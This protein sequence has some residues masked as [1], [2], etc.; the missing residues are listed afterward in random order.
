MGDLIPTDIVN[1]ICDFI[2]NNHLIKIA[3]SCSELHNKLE[4]RLNI[5][6]QRH[7]LL[8]DISI[9]VNTDRC[10]SCIDFGSHIGKISCCSQKTGDSLFC[11]LCNHLLYV[12]KTQVS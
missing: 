7:V 9:L 11:T 6:K 1:L 12:K 3:L 2:P 5:Y 10:F 8:E 4:T